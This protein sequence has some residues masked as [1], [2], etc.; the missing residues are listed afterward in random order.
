[1]T[2][3]SQAFRALVWKELIEISRYALP[4]LAA[5]MVFVLFELNKGVETGVPATRRFGWF[6]LLTALMGFVF[7]YGQTGRER[8]PDAWAFA[9]HRPISRQRIFLSKVIT[10]Q[11]VSTI[12]AG[13]PYLLAV[14][15]LALRRPGGIPAEQLVWT[16]ITGILMGNIGHATGLRLGASR[17]V[18]PRG[19]ALLF[20][21]MGVTA[22]SQSSYHGTGLIA[23]VVVAIVVLHLAAAAFE[24]SSFR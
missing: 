14:G 4:A 15:W 17:D 18:L 16:G 12:V 22:A 7:G 9:V 11:L 5:Y 6:G 10:G 21:L 20:G 23:G 3:S 19:A 13:L 2:R 1:M 8:D 24:Q